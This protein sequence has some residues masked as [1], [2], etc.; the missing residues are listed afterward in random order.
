MFGKLGNDPSS[1][2]PTEPLRRAGVVKELRIHPEKGSK[3]MGT[4]TR[5]SRQ[6]GALPPEDP[7]GEAARGG[8]RPV[9]VRKPVPG[10]ADAQRVCHARAYARIE[11]EAPAA[12]AG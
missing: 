8:S 12:P 10:G 11:E 3:P 2:R 7:G 6:G 5:R 1:A 9:G 4:R